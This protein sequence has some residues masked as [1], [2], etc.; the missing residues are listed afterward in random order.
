MNKQMIVSVGQRYFV[1]VQMAIL[2]EETICFRK[3]FV[4][5]EGLWLSIFVL[6]STSN[7]M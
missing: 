5:P 6:L 2:R 1:S 4:T 3:T 7:R